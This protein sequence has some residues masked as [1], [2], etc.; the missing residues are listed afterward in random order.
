MFDEENYYTDAVDFLIF[1]GYFAKVGN[2]GRSEI[3]IKASS[4][5]K[6]KLKSIMR[7]LNI[8]DYKVWELIR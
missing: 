3:A 7:Q 6:G 1:R 2:G 5:Y 4:P 8:E